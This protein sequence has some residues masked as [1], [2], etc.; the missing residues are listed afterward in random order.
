MEDD[1]IYDFGLMDE[2]ILTQN[3]NENQFNQDGTYNYNWQGTDYSSSWITPVTQGVNTFTS[4]I[5]GIANVFNDFGEPEPT[6]N[7]NP[8]Q[9]TPKTSSMMSLL[10][11]IGIYLILK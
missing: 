6:N 3:M 7:A 10:P 9:T 8:V 11:I 1:Y 5:G 2:I 4:L